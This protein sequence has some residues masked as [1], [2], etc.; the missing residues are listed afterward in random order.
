MTTAGRAEVA[1]VGASAQPGSG[2]TVTRI[3]LGAQLRKLRETAGLA[4]EQA[5]HAIRA[6]TSKIS[7]LELGQVAFKEHDVSDLLALYGVRDEMIRHR[8]LELAER[9][10]RPNWWH[11]YADVMPTWSETYVSLER[12]A[13]QIRSYEVQFVPDLLQTEGYARAVTQ[14]RHAAAPADEL[15]R[16]VALLME[17]Q[18]L[19]TRGEAPRLWAVIDEAALRRPVGGRAVL[20]EQISALI[21]ACDLRNVTVQVVPF[22]QGGHAAA[23]GAFSILRFAEPD[24]PDVVYLEQLQSAIYLKKREDVDFYLAVMNRLSVQAKP[25]GETQDVLAQLLRELPGRL[26]GRPG[27]AMDIRAP[28]A[29]DPRHHDITVANVYRQA[30]DRAAQSPAPTYDVERGL[31]RLHQRI[32]DMDHPE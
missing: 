18:R 3:L 11:S 12:V 17:R 9:A 27:P 7:R 20:R 10:N 29:D 32:Q 2:P 15:D 4:Q 31:R 5:G 8:L 19:L 30:R 13:S 26:A 16:R 24:L 14:L 21:E 1:A 22:E 25:A 28:T 23:G 6:S